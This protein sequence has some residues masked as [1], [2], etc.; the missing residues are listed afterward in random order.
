MQVAFAAALPK[1]VASP[2]CYLTQFWACPAEGGGGVGGGLLRKN[3]GGLINATG[4]QEHV[5]DLD[6]FP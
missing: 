4:T 5:F 6:R 1:K 2:V 3:E